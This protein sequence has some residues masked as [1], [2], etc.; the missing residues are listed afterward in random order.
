[1]DSVIKEMKCYFDKGTGR[2]E[3]YH[4]KDLQVIY[5]Y[6]EI[7]KSLLR[8]KK[9]FR[10]LDLGCGTG[11]E[12]ERVFNTFQDIFVTCVDASPEILGKM[13]EKFS[14]FKNMIQPICSSYLS[15]DFGI[16]LYDCVLSTCSLHYFSYLQKQEL[17]HRVRNSLK[18]DGT[19]ING[20]YLIK[21]IQKER[22]YPEDKIYQKWENG[23]L[24]EPYNY[25]TPLTI[26]TEI[27]LLNKAGF[28]NVKIFR[29]WKNRAIIIAKK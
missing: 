19:F 26:R 29:Q 22:L 11:Y 17:Y 13:M 3:D 23:L 8:C 7:E 6:D 18:P 21:K 20:D 4:R 12:L 25:D 5:F 15:I 9:C 1:M 14:D 28:S 16:E 24:E 10:L 27:M 2:Y